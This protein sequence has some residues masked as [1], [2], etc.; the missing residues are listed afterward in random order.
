MLSNLFAKE[1]II[2]KGETMKKYA[3]NDITLLQY[4]FLINGMQVATGIL[5]LPRVLAEKAGTDGW[6]AILMTF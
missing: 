6:I 4:I 5:S 3:Y 2:T 1:K